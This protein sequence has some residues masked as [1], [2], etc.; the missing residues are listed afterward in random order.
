MDS[1]QIGITTFRS[2]QAAKISILL[3]LD[4]AFTDMKPHFS[5]EKKS[6]FERY[7]PIAKVVNEHDENKMIELNQ[8]LKG[9]KDH[10]MPLYRSL[11]LAKTVSN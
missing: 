1:R 7:Q 6:H 2:V 4:V 8:C 9:K 3:F 11:L 5:Q 10:V